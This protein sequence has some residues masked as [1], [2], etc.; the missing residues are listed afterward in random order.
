[1]A[2]NNSKRTGKKLRHVKLHD[3]VMAIIAMVAARDNL[4]NTQVVEEAVL[5]IHEDIE[6]LIQKAPTK[7]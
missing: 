5:M 4:T 2:T 7:Q 3:P 6:K 1:M